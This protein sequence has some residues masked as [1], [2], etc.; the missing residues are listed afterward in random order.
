MRRSVALAALALPLSMLLAVQR[1][2]GESAAPAV[3][4]MQTL[5]LAW[6]AA[7]DRLEQAV[8]FLQE[9]VE[10]RT[11]AERLAAR[12]GWGGPAPAGEARSLRLVEGVGGPYVEV[13]WRLSGQAALGWAERYRELRRAL[14]AEGL[15]PQ[16]QVELAG[17][18]KDADPLALAEAALDAVGARQREPWSDG[19]S[20]SVAGYTPLLPPGPYAVNVQAAARRSGG[21]SRLW[22]AWPT[23]RSDY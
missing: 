3:A 5:G 23:V 14:A 10:D 2:G 21:G 18:G 4:E 11:A 17:S 22:V 9:P 13:T 15:W 16:V 12:L 8:L 6:E 1:P 20:A 7:G 19:R